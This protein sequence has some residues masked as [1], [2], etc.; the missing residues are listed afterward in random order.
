MNRD[1]V[2]VTVVLVLSLGSGLAWYVRER[3]SR[4]VH[5]PDLSVVESLVGQRATAV[6]MPAA[7]L[8]FDDSRPTNR[9][10]VDVSFVD[11]KMDVG[12]E[13]RR[14]STARAPRR[15][16]DPTMTAADVLAMFEEGDQEGL[17]ALQADL[18]AA[19]NASLPLLEALLGAGIWRAERMAIRVLSQIDSTEARLIGVGQLL[20]REQP[21]RRGWHHLA[22]MM[23]RNMNGEMV[24]LLAAMSADAEGESRRR[25]L[26]LLQHVRN[27]DGLFR[28]Y[29]LGEEDPDPAVRRMAVNT[30]FRG[31]RYAGLP[32]LQDIMLS[33][34]N[35]EV[36]ALAAVGIAEGGWNDAL[37][38][39]AEAGS[40]GGAE[41]ELALRALEQARNP[42][43][44]RILTQ[45]ANDS[46]YALDVRV[47]AVRALGNSARPWHARHSLAHLAA[48][49]DTP[50]VR[51]AAAALLEESS[52][53]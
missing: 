20:T 18:I 15:G 4:D 26:T 44:R 5:P 33:H 30:V 16:H 24:D 48:N 27:E 1:T 36:A 8:D 7:R 19:G 45:I 12:A 39:L 52:R 34:E 9:A 10:A 28:L 51:D 43:S 32:L 31:R 14:D 11:A 46:D 50:A 37:A 47:A 17:R 49:A 53:Q 25:L 21:V 41:A 3:A 42:R 2:I 29:M 13:A 38:F 22:A 6:A 35:P 40:G 23:G